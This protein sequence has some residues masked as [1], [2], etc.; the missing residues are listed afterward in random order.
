MKRE[1]RQKV[2]YQFDEVAFWYFGVSRVA[3]QSFVE[4]AQVFYK[5]GCMF[6]STDLDVLKIHGL[7]EEIGYVSKGELS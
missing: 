1:W 2:Y 5:D 3:Y 7:A 6:V 4:T